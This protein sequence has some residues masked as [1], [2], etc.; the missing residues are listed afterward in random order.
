MTKLCRYLNDGPLCP[1]KHNARLKSGALSLAAPL[2]GLG[3]GLYIRRMGHSVSSN[4][5]RQ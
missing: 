5:R 4:S 1:A 2:V 3:V